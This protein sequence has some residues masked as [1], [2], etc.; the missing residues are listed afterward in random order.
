MSA[1]MA[2]QYFSSLATAAKIK[3]AQRRLAAAAVAG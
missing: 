2:N 1:K 3:A